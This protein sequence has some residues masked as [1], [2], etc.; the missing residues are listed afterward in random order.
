MKVRQKVSDFIL[1]ES[2]DSKDVECLDCDEDL[3]S[4]GIIDSMAIVKLLGFVEETFLIEIEDD[5]LLPENF[6]TINAITNLI[7]NKI[8]TK[9]SSSN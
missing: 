8:K 1:N 9:G 5:E 3:I 7:G 6:E 4:E 2:M